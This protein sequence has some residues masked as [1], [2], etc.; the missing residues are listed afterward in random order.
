MFRG[1]IDIVRWL[2]VALAVARGS[3]RARLSGRYFC[4]LRDRGLLAVG[5]KCLVAP[6]KYLVPIELEAEARKMFA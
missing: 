1:G 6:C 4:R 5:S 3:G 2:R